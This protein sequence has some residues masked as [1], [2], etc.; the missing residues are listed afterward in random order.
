M[1]LRSSSA[2]YYPLKG[3]R[4]LESTLGIPKASMAIVETTL[5]PLL[6]ALETLSKHSTAILAGR[7]SKE[8]YSVNE[9]TLSK[10]SIAILA[11]RLSKEVYSINKT[12]LSKHSIAILAGRPSSY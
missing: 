10:H 1:R 4:T 3:L 11:G 7:L 9:T 5:E 12:T 6:D 8:V 2:Y